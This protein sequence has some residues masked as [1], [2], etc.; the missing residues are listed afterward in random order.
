MIAVAVIALSLRTPFSGVGAL[1]S[2]IQKDMN[3]SS[4]IAGMMTTIPLIMFALTAPLAGVISHYMDHR[5]MIQISLALTFA[6][7]LIRS[8]LGLAGLFIGT[9]IAGI[10]VGFLNVLIP[11]MIRREFPGKIGMM[12]SIYTMSMTVMS[13]VASGSSVWFAENLHGWNHSLA[14]F[15]V[16]PLSALIIWTA[17]S[18]NALDSGANRPNPSENASLEKLFC[19]HNVYLA[20]LMGLQAFLFFSMIAWLP[21]ILIHSGIPENTA[22]VFLLA[23][24]LMSVVSNLSIPVIV[25][26][27]K[28]KG[29]FAILAASLY[30][31]G[32]AGL[33]IKNPSI[34]LVVVSIVLLGLANGMSLSLALMFITLSGKNQRQST[35][36]SA[37]AQSL[38]YLLASPGS[39][40]M[41]ALFD[42]TKSWFLPIVMAMAISV[43]MAVAGKRAGDGLKCLDKPDSEQ[44]VR[45]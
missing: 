4:G 9:M 37:F 30:L 31:V 19:I 7:M 22:A 8:Y 13:A 14:I 36:L 33:L 27:S 45:E 15:G 11:V 2:F 26:Y 5:A 28:H 25:Q 29:A 16:L 35:Q 21:S 39:F 17:A 18:A 20:L 34:P 12:T 38:G 6:G 42:W 23:L 24:Q 41:G 44:V 40:L 43:F 32:L 3:L 1:V 10:G